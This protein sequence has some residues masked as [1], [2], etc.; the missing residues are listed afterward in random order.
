VLVP[1]PILHGDADA[2]VR[3]TLAELVSSEIGGVVLRAFDAASAL[4]VLR[5]HQPRP[6]AVLLDVRLGPGEALSSRA[7]L[8]AMRTDPDLR[9]VPVITMSGAPLPPEFP[10]TVHLEKPFGSEELTQALKMV[11]KLGPPSRP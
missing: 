2:D 1:G 5:T 7:L 3:D 6:Q 10:S 4:L 8:E 11:A 9:D